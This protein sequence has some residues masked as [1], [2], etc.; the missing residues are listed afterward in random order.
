M[1]FLIMISENLVSFSKIWLSKISGIILLILTGFLIGAATPGITPDY[2]LYMTNYNSRT[3]YFESG[4]NLLS[5]IGKNVGFEYPKFRMVMALLSV[6]LLLWGILRITNNVAIVAFLYAISI[7]PVDAIQIRNSFMLSIVVLAFTFVQHSNVKSY[8]VTAIIL[9]LASSTHTLALTF[10]IPLIISMFRLETQKVFA[11]AL[12]ILSV[13]IVFLSAIFHSEIL[14]ISQIV[15]NIFNFRSSVVGNVAAVYS[16]AAGKRFLLIAGIIAIV[17]L[18]LALY[19][20]NWMRK[21]KINNRLSNSIIPIMLLG[22][23]AV[24]LMTV[25]LDYC[26]LLRNTTMF[27]YIYIAAFVES[28]PKRKRYLYLENFGVIIC[29]MFLAITTYYLQNVILYPNSG[30]IIR[31]TIHLAG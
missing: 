3:S 5:H 28:H 1:A 30:E 16:N 11:K 24:A 20:S 25:S 8:L 4:Y 23:I 18:Y 17:Q 22:I 27:I 15:L 19:M 26:R 14:K 9:F 12:I 7:F 10:A 6:V 13:I 2:T 21:N 29:G 31:T